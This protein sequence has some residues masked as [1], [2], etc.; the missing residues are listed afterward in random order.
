MQNLG[1]IPVKVIVTKDH[2][3]RDQVE[4]MIDLEHFFDLSINSLD[5]LKEF[6]ESYLN[7]IRNAKEI[8]DEIRKKRQIGNSS[9]YWKLGLLLDDFLNNSA[10]FNFTNYRKAFE[11]EIGLTDTLIGILLDFPKVFE[12]KEVDDRIPFSY[13]LELTQKARKLERKNQLTKAKEELHR[14]VI[15]T[16][17]PDTMQFRKNLKRMLNE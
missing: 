10:K 1:K 11:R 6:K 13:Y 9:L 5:D 7:L 12:K 14:V 4:T 16:D 17:H 2:E 8:L 15:P 3:G